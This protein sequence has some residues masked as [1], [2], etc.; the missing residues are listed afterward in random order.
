MPNQQPVVLASSGQRQFACSVAAVLVF[1]VNSDEQIL[2]LSHPQR[3]GKWEIV[4]GALQ[5]E[6]TLL[7]GA[8]REVYEEV[9][10]DIQVRPLGVIHA[11]SYRYDD[12][13]QYMI[14][15][16]FVAAYEGGGVVPG[17]DME[18]SDVH[19]FDLDDIESD[20]VDIVVPSAPRWLFRR[21]VEFYRTHKDRPAVRL[22]P[23]YDDLPPTKYLLNR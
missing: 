14:T 22:Q 15:V 10:A 7:D 9:G 23:S 2:M 4:N 18:G 1:I 11:Y 8:L 17:D 16:C 12:T 21:A 20:T 13:I 6:E 3:N 5:A 19:W